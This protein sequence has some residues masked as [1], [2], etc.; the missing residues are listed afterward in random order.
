[1]PSALEEY[2]STYGE[3]LRSMLGG[4]SPLDQN[5]TVRPQP[6]TALGRSTGEGAY[7]PQTDDSDFTAGSSDPD[8]PY[9]D[10]M[11]Q[12][13]IGDQGSALEQ[14]APAHPPEQDSPMQAPEQGQGKGYSFRDA[15]DDSSA[16]SKNQQVT[17]L[18]EALKRGN[19]TID[20][21]YD[22]LEKQLGAPP[23]KDKKLSRQDKGMLL[24]EFGLNLMANSRKGF[25]TAAGQAGA[26]T[27]GTYAK[28]KQGPTDEYNRKKSA[29][30]SGRANSKVNLAGQ[31][32][33]E[34]LKQP[35]QA[36]GRLPGKFVGDDGYVYFYDANNQV[37]QAKD[38]NGKPIKASQAERA[39][40]GG[41]EFESDAKFKRYM[42]IYGNDPRTGKPLT[43]IA[44]QRVKQDG[45]DFAND[46]GT[47]L[48]DLDLD[49]Q[50]EK[51]ADD[52]MSHHPE[53]FD[54]MTADQVNDY[55]NKLADDRR[56]RLKRKTR[57]YLDG[58]TPEPARGRGTK[59]RFA[60]SADAQAAYDRG[61]IQQGDTIVVNGVEGPVE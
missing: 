29:I 53:L 54:G 35:Q 46:R 55:R 39:G 26:Q 51:S 11:S 7:I 18:E 20:A 33:L 17:K 4:Q 13:E 57:S 40:Q 45:F 60:N 44:L 23:S 16:E 8:A 27:L 34:G 61:E 47:Q 38:A 5:P 24:M 42:E 9:T 48:D 3:R 10:E 37:S 43:G 50:A 12:D 6:G 36:A 28:I 14:Q 1:M 49:V 31:S 15:W 30:E 2:G 52:F 25:A 59:R 32:A 41:K 19:Q 56:R 21:A 58:S 22:E